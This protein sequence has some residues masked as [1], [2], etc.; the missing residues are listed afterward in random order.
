MDNLI[1]ITVRETTQSRELG[2]EFDDQRGKQDDATVT[3]LFPQSA[4]GG[5]QSAQ[6][7]ISQRYRPGNRY[8]YVRANGAIAVY[9][10]LK[11]DVSFATAIQR[12]ANV[13]QTTN[14]TAGVNPLAGVYE[15]AVPSG[16]ATADAANAIAS[17]TFFFMTTRGLAP[18][19]TGAVSA[20]DKLVAITTA[21]TLNTLN[22]AGAYAQA[23]AQQTL[24]AASGLGAVA[25][26]A[27]GTP[28]AGT[29]YVMLQ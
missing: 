12:Y 18:V 19:L 17:G 7:Y 20:G 28:V 10:A 11:Y 5:G 3:R 6:T 27:N 14:S 23:E 1:D 2:L 13:I 22:P 4:G 26:T 21:G 25:M 24:Q 9:N 15:A 16:T 29:A 8:K